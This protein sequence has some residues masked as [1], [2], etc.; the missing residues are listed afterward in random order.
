MSHIKRQDN[1]QSPVSI[2]FPVDLREP[3]RYFPDHAGELAM[4][5]ENKLL[6]PRDTLHLLR[7]ALAD[8]VASLGEIP[9]YADRYADLCALLDLLNRVVYKGGERPSVYHH[10]ESSPLFCK[11][12]SSYI[13][14]QSADYSLGCVEHSDPD[15]RKLFTSQK[16]KLFDEAK[17]GLQ[18]SDKDVFSMAYSC[19]NLI[20]VDEL[21]F[22]YG[23][24]GRQCSDSHMTRIF[25]NRLDAERF[26]F[27]YLLE[28]TPEIDYV[29]IFSA[30]GNGDHTSKLFPDGI[31]ALSDIFK[32]KGQ[33]IGS[34]MFFEWLKKSG[35]SLEEF[36]EDFECVFSD[37]EWVR[38]YLAIAQN[39]EEVGACQNR[40]QFDPSRGCRWSVW[41]TSFFKRMSKQAL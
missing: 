4:G 30:L 35:V 39:G 41:P 6:Q 3:K 7:I 40:L 9:K 25:T 38:P 19:P 14:N 10:L 23:G 21:T 27:K 13:Y 18:T 15:K 24:A 37:S 33:W 8:V 1:F 20:T 16:Q 11:T 2:R 12:V 28:H 29:E 36:W 22:Y 31:G 34:R 5:E 32:D 17:K 26:A